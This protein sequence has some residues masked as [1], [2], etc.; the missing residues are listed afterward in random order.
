MLMRCEPPTGELA[1]CIGLTD[2]EIT[3]IVLLLLLAERAQERLRSLLAPF[4][5]LPVKPAA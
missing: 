5:D 3:R 2:E 4:D 1:A